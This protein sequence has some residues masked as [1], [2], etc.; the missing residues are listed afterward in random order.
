MD[1]LEDYER[2]YFYEADSYLSEQVY[3]CDVCGTEFV[4]MRP[5]QKRCSPKCAGHAQEIALG[6]GRWVVLNRDGFRCAYCGATAYEDGAKLHVDHVVPRSKGG[7]DTV[8]NLITA[9][10]RCNLEKSTVRV[11][12]EEPLI[13]EIARRN[14]VS[15]LNAALEIRMG[16]G[17]HTALN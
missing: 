13:R 9:C 11:L 12:D 10:A 2:T 8:A 7:R 6:R 5:N 15:G 3:A 14:E 1:V 16:R 17:M 4:P